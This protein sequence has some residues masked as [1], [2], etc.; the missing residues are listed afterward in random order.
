MTNAI[1]VTDVFEENDRLRARVAELEFRLQQ[2]PQGL[3]SRFRLPPSLLATLAL[4]LR[5][6]VIDI[7]KFE[8]DENTP[9]D[10]KVTIHRLRKMLAP[11]KI[12]IKSRRSTG[13]WID[14]AD[15]ERIKEM[16]TDTVNTASDGV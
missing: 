5:E 8:A 6:P 16:I 7:D 9:K 11:H 14:D 3:V 10:I 15:K 2:S 4:L 13:Y 12:D 1:T